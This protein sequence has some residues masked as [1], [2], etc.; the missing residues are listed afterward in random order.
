MMENNTGNDSML[1]NMSGHSSV[2]PPGTSIYIPTVLYTYVLPTMAF[3]GFVGN[4][5]SLFAFMSKELKNISSSVYVQ[6]VLIA[7][8]G[9]LISL[10]FVWLEVLGY[11]LN[12]LQVMC[13]FLVFWQYVCSFLSVWYMVCI[14]TE[15]YITICHPTRINTMCTVP[16]ATKVT[17][18]LAITALSLYIVSVFITKPVSD[19]ATGRDYCSVET[20]Y[21]TLNTVITYIDSCITLLIPALFIILLITAILLS[22]AKS[23]KMKKKRTANRKNKRGSSIPQV[24][25]AKMLLCLSL[26]YVVLSVPSHVIK[27]YFLF[28]DVG[29]VIPH[30]AALIQL[31]FLFVS[32]L[33][34]SVKFILFAACSSNFRNVQFGSCISSMSYQGV[35]QK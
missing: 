3:L 8:T 15:N 34:F 4:I 32:Y 6:G 29:G 21:K 28:V 11:R 30:E 7:D 23:I 5:A 17:V 10:F 25:V 12:H 26:T 31:I 16:R 1:G 18:S 33:N 27:L 2:Q 20:Q 19:P 22:I 24:R 9:M 14:T 13:Q 35:I